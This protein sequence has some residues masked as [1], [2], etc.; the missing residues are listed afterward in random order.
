MFTILNDPYTKILVFTL[1][2]ARHK[3]FCNTITMEQGFPP[4][5]KLK[6]I[7][8]VRASEK[9]YNKISESH[10]NSITVKPS[11]NTDNKCPSVLTQKLSHQV[12]IAKRMLS[13]SVTI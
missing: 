4:I 12:S 1:F 13:Y 11:I 9:Y 7:S 6:I 10:D 2:A 8:I 5:D 3:L